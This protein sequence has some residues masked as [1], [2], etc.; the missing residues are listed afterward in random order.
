MPPPLRSLALAGITVCS[1]SGVFADRAMVERMLVPRGQFPAV[2]H[3]NEMVGALNEG[4]VPMAKAHAWARI[5]HL[6]LTNGPRYHPDR[7]R[8]L[9]LLRQL[10]GEAEEKAPAEQPP[11][12]IKLNPP[13]PQIRLDE[14]LDEAI[15][16][17]E[18]TKRFLD[19]NL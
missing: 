14:G 10:T 6:T 17:G 11:P 13:Q 15:D 12:E 7:Q 18:E 3:Y 2:F 5:P 8:A 4:N 19:R 16:F 9:M 1:L